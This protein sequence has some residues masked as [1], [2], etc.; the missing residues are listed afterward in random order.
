MKTTK[1]DIQL[2][3]ADAW[4]EAEW[5]AVVH[6][7]KKSEY[8]AYCLRREWA[9]AK[10]KMTGTDKQINYAF[11]LKKQAIA[12]IV[13][14]MHDAESKNIAWYADAAH[15][16]I[17]VIDMYRGYAGTLIDA[18][19]DLYAPTAKKTLNRIIEALK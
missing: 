7:G 2:I 4:K 9:R 13:R 12:E 11:D 1:Y 16:T 19:K 3:V 14:I 8:F 17:E 18:L 5:A 10:T 15:H 6:G